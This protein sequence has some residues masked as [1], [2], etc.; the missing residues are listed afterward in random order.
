[1]N[2]PCPDMQ[3]RIADYVLGALDIAQAQAV[4]EHVAG[5]A[6]CRQYLESLER[7]GDALAELGRRIETDMPARQDRAIAA[8]EQVAPPESGRV[9]PF[10]SGFVRTAVAAVLLLGVGGVIGRWTA[11]RPVDVEQFRADLEISIAASLTPAVRA[12]VLAEVD[13]RL[14]TEL[15]ANNAAIGVELADQVRQ[16]LR[17]F[18]AQ[19]AAGS[20][21]LMARQY[22]EL[23]GLI[24]AGR[25]KDR[26]QVARALDQ[27]KRQTNRGLYSLAVHTAESPASVQN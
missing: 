5:C 8:L 20:Q 24:E 4:R 27:I 21:S 10:V 9:L 12:S 13:Q 16:E 15:A 1:M 6:G 23:V 17:A 25:E 3:D 18:A 26:E 22:T 11:P 19:F 2:R 7:Q 14:Q